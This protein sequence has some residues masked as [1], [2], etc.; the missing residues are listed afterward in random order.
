MKEFVNIL[1][2]YWIGKFRRGDFCIKDIER[3]YQSVKK[4][5]DR[6]FKFYCLTNEKFEKLPKHVIPIQLDYAWP[7]W[8][9]KME[10]FRSD[11]PKGRILYLD[12]ASHVIRSLQPILDYEGDLVMFDTRIPEKKFEALKKKGWVCRYQNATML[13]DSGTV[14][15]VEIYNKF[16]QS[17]KSWMRQYRSDQDIMGAWVP[18][19]P[20]FPNE[21]MIKLGTIRDYQQPPDDCS[22]VTGQTRD[23]LFRRRDSM[24]CFEQLA[25]GLN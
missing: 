24:P 18:N 3:L 11:L 1:C 23:G 17:P 16:L 19:Q 7:G 13:F 21:W 20:T 9:S 15:M 4:H 22:L 10:L 25:G 12:L 2:L 8:W 6:D 14:C 5:I